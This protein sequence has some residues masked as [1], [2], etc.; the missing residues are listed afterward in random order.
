[1][2]GTSNMLLTRSISDLISERN[3]VT[4]AAAVAAQPTDEAAPPPVVTWVPNP[5]DRCHFCG[6]RA[7][8]ETLFFGR[9][10]GICEDC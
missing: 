6:A 10:I 9:L 8:D 4:A 2:L 7:T 3:M 1:M 5:L